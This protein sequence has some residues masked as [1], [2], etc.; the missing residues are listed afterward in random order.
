MSSNS[1]RGSAV[2]VVNERRTPGHGHLARGITKHGQ[3]ARATKDIY[4]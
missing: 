2:A 1:L 4:A 3:D